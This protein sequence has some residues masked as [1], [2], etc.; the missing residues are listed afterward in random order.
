MMMID[1]DFDL[2]ESAAIKTQSLAGRV[3]E[4]ATAVTG[5]ADNVGVAWQGKSSTNYAAEVED[6]SVR[7]RKIADQL[8]SLYTSIKNY[9]TE[10]KRLEKELTQKVNN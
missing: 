8:D 2:L 10:M 9:T 7:L 5:I 1:I 6:T 3:R 4:S